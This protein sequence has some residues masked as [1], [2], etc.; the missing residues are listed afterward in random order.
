MINFSY[1][2][3]RLNI[4]IE[5]IKPRIVCAIIWI[6]SIPYLLTAHESFEYSIFLSM[7]IG[8]ALVSGGSGSLNMLLEN[9]LDQMMQRTKN[10][11]IPSKKIGIVE[12]FFLSVFLV[13]TGIVYLTLSTGIWAGFIAGLV[14]YFYLVLYTPLKTKS[15]ISIVFGAIAGALPVFIGLSWEKVTTGNIYLLF[16]VVF[17]WQIPHLAVLSWIYREDYA[18][19]K[20][21]IWFQDN[22][23]LT[24]KIL[25]FISLVCMYL[26]CLLYAWFNLTYSIFSIILIS[27]IWGWGL[28]SCICFFRSQTEKNGK[29]FFRWTTLYLFVVFLIFL[30]FK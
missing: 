12:S 24:S 7:L 14:L 6:S 30:L 1:I 13:T 4:Y 9:K 5:C 26:S 19:T 2:A 10:R 29:N 23:A 18:K 22:N 11:P 25:I 16:L 15:L 17:F 8:T 21:M 20:I 27:G 3:Q 28:Y